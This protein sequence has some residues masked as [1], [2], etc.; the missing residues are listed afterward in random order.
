MRGTITA[1][2][3]AALLLTGCNTTGTRHARGNADALDAR[4]HLVA[5]GSAADAVARAA[6]IDTNG[7]PSSIVIERTTRTRHTDRDTTT[8][9]ATAGQRVG[10]IV[11]TVGGIGLV[12]VIVLA[13]FCPGILAAFAVRTAMKWRAAFSQTVSAISASRAVEKNPQLHDALKAAQTPE[14]KELVARVKR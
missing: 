3:A 13:V 12:L 1:A 11:G 8:P 2:A 6:A 4:T 7:V 9:P 10:A 5:H 14:T